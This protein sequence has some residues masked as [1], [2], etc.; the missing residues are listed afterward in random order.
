[1]QGDGFGTSNSI[2]ANS[3]G[4]AAV[5]RCMS[6]ERLAGLDRST[7]SR[8]QRLSVAE[9]LPGSRGARAVA[10]DTPG[11]S[12]RVGQASFQQS[13]RNALQLKHPPWKYQPAQVVP[14]AKEGRRRRSAFRLP[15]RRHLIE[16]LHATATYGRRVFVSEGVRVRTLK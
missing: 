7:S 9:D 11:D 15:D 16:A 5:I 1:M 6:A 12:R 3:F 14:S 10:P 13:D 8:D 2:G 4:R